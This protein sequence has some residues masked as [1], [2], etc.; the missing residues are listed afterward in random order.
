M[1]LTQLK[2]KLLPYNK[3]AI[4]SEDGLYRYV[5]YR[6]WVEGLPIAQVIGLNPSKADS[7]EDDP[8]IVFLSLA[9]KKLGYG[10]L[11]MTNVFALVST[12]PEALR[13]CPNPIKDNDMYLEKIRELSDDVIFAWGNF[14]QAVYR[15]KVMVRMFPGAKCFG[16][17]KNG[18]PA[19]PLSLMYTGTINN[20]KLIDY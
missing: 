5:L 4:F 6:R 9:L 7:K 17:N 16:K 11:L 13:T 1:E 12:E 10:A 14:K 20:P 3:S 15:E 19:H 18:S 8:T 2:S